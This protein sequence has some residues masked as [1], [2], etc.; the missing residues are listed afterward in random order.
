MEQESHDMDYKEALRSYNTRNETFKENKTKAFTYIIE[1]CNKTMENRIHEGTNYDAILGDPN[2]LLVEIKTKM[3]DPARAKYT[4]ASLTKTLRRW[5][6]EE[7]IR[8]MDILH[9]S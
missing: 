8:E 4:Y 1:F 9:V 3:H 6:Y 7:C 5:H 2:A